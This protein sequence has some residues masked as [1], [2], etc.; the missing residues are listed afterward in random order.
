M[1]STRILSPVSGGTGL[2]PVEWLERHFDQA[3]RI[4]TTVPPMF[5]IKPDDEWGEECGYDHEQC[6]LCH[7]KVLEIPDPDCQY[8]THVGI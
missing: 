6:W 1:N 4:Y 7:P 5:T 3:P 8:V 2:T